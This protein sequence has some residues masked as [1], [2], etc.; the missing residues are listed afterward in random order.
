M[1]Q[2]QHV[3]IDGKTHQQY[4][5]LGEDT[6]TLFSMHPTKAFRFHLN[7]ALN[8]Y[9]EIEASGWRERAKQVSGMLNKQ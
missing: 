7:R 8:N 9:L 2:K 1:S 5:K 3:V 6:Q 4:K